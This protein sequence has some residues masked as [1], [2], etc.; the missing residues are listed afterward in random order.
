MPNKKDDKQ[1]TINEKWEKD[2]IPKVTKATKED[3][4]IIAWY[5][6]QKKKGN[7]K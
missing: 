2:G 3:L 1:L 6:E 4:A 5:E 7:K